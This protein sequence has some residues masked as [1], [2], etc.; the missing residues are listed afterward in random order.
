MSGKGYIGKI[1]AIV[2]VNTADASRAFNRSGK[3]AQ[4]YAQGMRRAIEQATRDAGK[5]FDNIFT[6][7]QKLQRALESSRR[8]D[9]NLGNTPE[10][11]EQIRTVEQLAL[12]ARQLASPLATA[13]KQFDGLAFSVQQ[14]FGGALSRTQAELIRV[15]DTIQTATDGG[16]AG[17]RAVTAQVNQTIASI[18]QL[19]EASQRVSALPTGQE[20]AF[21]DPRLSANLNAAATAGQRAVALPRRVIESDPQIA[22][23]TAQINR[24][25]ELA[26]AAAARVKGA[27]GG[28]EAQAA[29]QDYERLNAVLERSIARLNEKYRLFID[30]EQAER[31]LEELQ[32][33]I[34]EIR[35]AEDFRIT[36]NF[37]NAKQV[38]SELQRVLSLR[39]QLSNSQNSRIQ[40]LVIE[41]LDAA[42]SGDLDASREKIDALRLALE[43][44]IKVNVDTR[45]ASS[46][47]AVL[48]KESEELSQRGATG[49]P[50]GPPLPPG[51]GGQ[52]DAGLGAALADPNRQLDALRGGITSVK[53]QIDQLPAGLR[54]QFIPAI[55]AAEAEFRRLAAAPNQSAVAI[56]IARQRLLQLTREAGRASEALNFRRSFGSR[57]AIIGSLQ[58]QQLRGY[59]AQVQILQGELANVTGFARGPAVA[60]IARLG[61]VISEQMRRGTV[62]TQAARQEVQRLVAD[63]VRAT[64]AAR[65]ISAGALGRT[66]ARAGDVGRQGFANL[67][68]GIQQAAFAF[69]DFFSVTGGLDQR[70]RAAGNN[71][72]QLGFVLGGTTGLITG[73]SVA[74]GAQL[75]ASIIKWTGATEDAEKRQREL[76]DALSSTNSALE[77]QRQ[78][79]EQLRDVYRD[80]AKSIAEAGEPER[81]RNERQQREQIAAVQRQQEERRRAAIE[82][83]SPQV[84]QQRGRIAEID[85]QLETEQNAATRRRLIERRNAADR[86]ARREIDDIERRGAENFG[87]LVQARGGIE[88][89]RRALTARGGPRE[90][91]QREIDAAARRGNEAEVSRLA[92]ELA[93]IENTIQRLADASV[94]L[95]AERSRP[96][97][98]R[99][100]RLQE[101]AQPSDGLLRSQAESLSQIQSAA[102]AFR[103]EIERLNN[104]ASSGAISFTELDNQLQQLGQSFSELEQTA[105]REIA[106]IDIAR[107]AV[108][109]FAE[110]LNKASQEAQANLQS[111]QS[112]ADAARR[113][114][115]GFSTP[116]TQQAR[117]QAE[118]DLGR[119]Q[120]LASSVEQEIAAARQRV[121]GEIAQQAAA[122]ADIARR[123]QEAEGQFQ[124]QAALLNELVAADKA[125][126]DLL[127]QIKEFT[128][129]GEAIPPELQKSFD[130]AF[131]RQKQAKEA[132]LA[133]GFGGDIIPG[134]VVAAR[135]LEDIKAAFAATIAGLDAELQASGQGIVGT[136]RRIAE[137]D[138]LLAT[139]GVLGGAGRDELVRERAALEQQAVEMDEQVRRARDEST[140]ESEQAA[141][142]SRGRQ[143]SMTD[144]ER[145]AADL[146]RGLEDIR[147]FFG[148]QA[149]ETTGLVDFEAQAAAQQRF[150][151]QSLRSAAPA[152]FGLADQVQNAVLQGPS[153][154]A[155]EARDVSTADGA[156]ELSR[157]LRGEDPARDA[158]LV[159]L[160]KQ[161]QLLQSLLDEAK[162]AGRP[163]VAEM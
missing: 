98:D 43:G 110:S 122:P 12:A 57:D 136:F 42:A 77:R 159:E 79:A 27:F 158:N 97:V 60:A 33:S 133:A 163:Q 39:D 128:R 129:R 145:A 52:S 155:L 49:G 83:N 4:T 34:A 146:T 127:Q 17:F 38:Q 45:E 113:A 2:T 54:Q 154:A 20:L 137:I 31:N 76:K 121:A 116:Q 3:E 53:S 74:I 7:F 102:Q 55:T 72:S 141:A 99:I 104:A 132:A 138:Q 153:R 48:Q 30:T 66:V 18:R 37:Q 56:D 62:D 50:Q 63:A 68:L 118:A 112:A 28:A 14:G 126:G 59:T 160:Q 114:D 73:I 44:E 135:E 100:T 140:R 78:L 24:V 40:P 134:V 161:S 46:R 144:G 67:S 64:A 41:A 16:E 131:G 11:K 148:R 5:S 86:A 101:Q 21:S 23:L 87:P 6:P 147:Q 139:Q 32:A 149:E 36:G 19:A 157:L 95:G 142:A 35:A 156:R 162:A 10:L 106:A 96:L 61:T 103:E 70:I 108:E 143:L 93:V 1:S 81:F 130:E 90:T 91:V 29:Q 119:Q 105:R 47:L 89:A 51:F 111:A 71:I 22:Q 84:A 124:E 107:Q 88:G 152:I 109:R 25:S 82:A 120:E 117:A 75:V 80:L 92:R 8:A 151:D 58:T 9:F 115:L 123:R 69:E 150:I 65:G 13:T 85:R 15:R 26:V 125:T 94:R